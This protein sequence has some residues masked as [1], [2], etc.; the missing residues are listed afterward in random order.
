MAQS[1]ARTSRSL[2]GFAAGI[3]RIF[4]LRA[5]GPTPTGAAV[6]S[7]F[8]SPGVSIESH[9]DRNA[10]RPRFDFVSTP[11]RLSIGFRRRVPGGTALIAPRTLL[12]RH[13]RP[14]L[15]PP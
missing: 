12:P 13:G 5:E 11:T 4:E 2:S 1:G 9:A 3:E 8:G 7:T 6:L 10:V 15:L 14:P